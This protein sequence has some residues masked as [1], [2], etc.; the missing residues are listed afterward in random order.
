MTLDT[1]ATAHTLA[2]FLGS[3]RYGSSLSIT[4]TG[5]AATVQFTNANSAWPVDQAAALLGVNAVW[6][7]RDSNIYPVEYIASG[8]WHGIEL[9]VLVLFTADGWTAAD[10]AS[11]GEGAA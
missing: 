9:T 3:L 5:G 8:P 6:H 7:V 1:V 10:V 11:T 2:L 4:L